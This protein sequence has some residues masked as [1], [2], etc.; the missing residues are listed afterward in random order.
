MKK[1]ITAIVLSSAALSANAANLATASLTSFIQTG[2]ISN[3]AASTASITSV[4]YTLGTAG[5]GIATWDS[6]SGSNLAGG[7]ASGF[8]SDARYF[9][10]I[11]FGGLNVGAGSSFS[12]SGLDIDLI[13]TLTPLSVTGAV[14]DEVGTSLVGASMSIFWSNGDSATTSLVQQAWSQTQSLSFTSAT[15]SV[16]VPAAA[17]LFATGLA[18]FAGFRR[19]SQLAA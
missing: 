14:L 12:F 9:Q 5:N 17:W 15:S 1:I 13:Q 7:V 3:D 2:T 16:P 8:L 18:G 19:K 6:N 4:V 10:T 11:T